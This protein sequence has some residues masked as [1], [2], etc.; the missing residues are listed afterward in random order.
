M[1]AETGCAGKLALFVAILRVQHCSS[2]LQQI[3]QVRTLY[4]SDMQA[5]AQEDIYLGKGR[6]IKD[7]PKKYPSKTE[8]TGVAFGYLCM[9]QVPYLFGLSRAKCSGFVASVSGT[10]AVPDFSFRM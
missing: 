6:F 2:H 5:N 7:D 1:Q 10:T 4:F 8:L 9:V 3:S